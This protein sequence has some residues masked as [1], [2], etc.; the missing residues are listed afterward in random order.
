MS[1]ERGRDYP[2]YARIL[3]L[4]TIILTAML[5]R[6]LCECSMVASSLNMHL[7]PMIGALE[8]R[9]RVIVLLEQLIG[10]LWTRLNVR[11]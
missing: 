1:Q 3:P 2:V 7:I 5:V 11:I 9:S 8:S 6:Q 10:A 4:S